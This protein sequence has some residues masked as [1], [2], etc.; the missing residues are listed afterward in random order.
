MGLAAFIDQQGAVSLIANGHA[1]PAQAT[2]HD[3]LQERGTLANCSPMGGGRSLLIVSEL[4]LVATKLFPGD[5]ACMPIQQYNGPVLLFD[6]AR[7]SLDPWFFPRERVPTR[8]RSPVDICSR[9]QRTVQH[10]QR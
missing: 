8:L 9:V 3:A 7:A 10:I 1:T 2:E 4:L 6:S 5:V